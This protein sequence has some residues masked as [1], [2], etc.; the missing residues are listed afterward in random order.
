[1][2]K[3][4]ALLR[5]INVGGKNK[6]PMAQL[7]LVFE[8]MGFSGV[9][10][11]INS[12][13]VI[14]DSEISDIYE[15]KSICEMAIL[16]RFSLSIPVVIISA[17]ELYEIVNNAPEWWDIEN[18]SINYMIF[19]IHPTCIE[20]IFE[21]IGDVKPEYEQ[22]THYRNIIFWAGPLKTFSKARWSKIASSSVSNKVIIRNAN[23][24]KK[25]LALTK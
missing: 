22:V 17:T 23:T 13:N 11:Y 3:Y 18:E 8:E 15:L 20:E 16:N 6:V 10:T 24:I 4:I 1:M 19:L 12:G 9:K 5:G 2:E 25:I 21:V 7:R 14:F